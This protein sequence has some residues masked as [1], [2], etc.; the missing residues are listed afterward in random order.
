[1]KCW[2]CEKKKKYQ[3]LD[4]SWNWSTVEFHDKD[5][6]PCIWFQNTEE[7]EP[8]QMVIKFCPICGRNL[9]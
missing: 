8:G 1:M 4:L 7:R 2:F 9:E 3:A 5:T 6:V